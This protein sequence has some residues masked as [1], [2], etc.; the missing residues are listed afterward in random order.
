[1]GVK[2]G[3][4]MY[5]VPLF[6][7]GIFWLTVMIISQQGLGD[8]FMSYLGATAKIALWSTFGKLFPF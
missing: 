7:R 6:R 3:L 4:E 2:S 8:P 5:E 1:M